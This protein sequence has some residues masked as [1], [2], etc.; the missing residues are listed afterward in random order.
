M[1]FDNLSR[2]CKEKNT[3]PSAVALAIGVSKSNVTKWKGGQTPKTENVAD[4]AN[5]LEV[6]I[7]DLIDK[8]KPVT[9]DDELPALLGEI[10]DN[11]KLL[12]EDYQK[13]V[14]AQI[15]AFPKSQK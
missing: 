5:H 2:I 15:K 1:F 7:W 10:M 12:N 9:D 8:E 3:S 6:D 11:V 4:I 13:I 14:L